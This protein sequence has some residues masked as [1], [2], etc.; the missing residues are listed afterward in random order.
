MMLRSCGASVSWA[1][2][3]FLDVLYIASQLF[4]KS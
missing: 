4:G 1:I 2:Q 3:V